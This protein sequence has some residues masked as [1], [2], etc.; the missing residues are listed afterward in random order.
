MHTLLLLRHAKSSQ[1]NPKLD[2]FDRPL[3][4]R[5]H[6]DAPRMGAEIARRGWQPDLVLVSTA[7]RARQTWQMA[8]AAF[9]DFPFFPHDHHQTGGADTD[10]MT[11]TK[12]PTVSRFE[13]GLYM[14]EAPEMLKRLHD[15]PDSARCVLVIGHNP[16]LEDLALMLAGPDSEQKALK[17]MNKKFPTAALARLTFDSPWAELSPGSATLTH[18]LRVKRLG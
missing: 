5:G 14:A 3:A 17:H 11:E 12:S 9:P 2:D 6:S 1:D 4:E 8:S 7:L 13:D 18:F 15:L 16:G 10:A